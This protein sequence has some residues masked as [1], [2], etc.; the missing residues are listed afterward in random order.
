[1]L[2]KV[3]AIESRSSKSGPALWIAA[4]AV[5]VVAAIALRN[6]TIWYARPIPSL[7]IDPGGSISNLGLPESGKK[8]GLKFPQ[9]VAPVGETK[10]SAGSRQRVAAWDRAVAAAAPVGHLDAW[11]ISE[12]DRRL[13]R[14]PFGPLEPQ[15]W[16]VYAGSCILAGILYAAAGLVALWASPT[17]R[18]SR[19]FA[20]FAISAG[21]LLLT[22][23]DAHTE[24]ALTP[25]FFLAY[26]LV[27][28]TLVLLM[29]NLPI[30]VAA[31]A[32]R[33]RLETVSLGVACAFGVLVVG[34]R[35]TGGDVIPFQVVLTTLFGM[36]F[37]V[38]VAG[39][40]VRYLRSRGEQRQTLRTL[41]V[42]M[43][44]VYAACSAFMVLASLGVLRG[45]PD[46]LFFPALIFAPLASL[47][48]FVRYDLWGSR[49]L[50]SR[51]GTS[52]VVGG[53]A[54]IAAIAAGAAFAAWMGAHFSHALAGAA[55]GGFAAAILV[56]LALRIS[57]FTLFRSRA[58]YKPT[59]E[60][61]G[62]ELTTLTSVEEVGQA[63]ESTVR[64]WLPC[65]SI[66]LALAPTASVSQLAAAGEG[67][68]GADAVPDSAPAPNAD[69]PPRDSSSELRMQVSFAGK[70]LGWLDVGAKRGG[71][72]FTSDDMDLLRAIANHGGLALAH[73]HAYQ[74]LEDRR[75]AQAQAWRGEREALV[76]TVAAEMAHEIRYPINY[77][78]SL[79]ERSA[80]GTKL[81]A[82]DIDVGRE[83]VD[84]LERLVSG[85]KRMA[86]HRIERS[87]TNV[88][89][90]CGRVEALLRDSLGKRPIE[91]SIGK[92]ATLR[93]DPDK[94]TQVLVNL[95][96]N[97]LEA[98]G[99]NGRVG[100]DWIATAQ[101]GE[102]R[103]WD[104]GPGFVG[105]ASRLFA[106]WYT[107]KPRGTGLGL[108][109]THRLVRAHGWNVAGVR[110]D[111][112]TV[113]TVSV[114]SEDI[115]RDSVPPKQQSGPEARV[116]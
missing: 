34:V 81:E 67:A 8:L 49:R 103:V 40:L 58:E 69:E 18:L 78:R 50:L 37:A 105:E 88:G 74:E 13:V 85:L 35:Q 5:A 39:F 70:P 45:F 7:L 15:A 83:E 96:S 110:R 87:P 31:L 25:V 97:G 79:F 94:M 92:D 42:S 113:F 46:F 38:S 51:I 109:I 90:L 68:D 33:P 98:C 73:A 6:A 108:A 112:R 26:S 22:V 99:P 11:V 115:V 64:R 44:P 71:A 82:E 3:R 30:P 62:E 106:P 1:M 104:D 102:L 32:K 66:R 23:F 52:L 57:D 100:V 55:G 61:L 80:T 4:A 72:L 10:G 75:Q 20:R 21:V 41:V 53:L 76:E 114:R 54:C 89:D 95:L 56:V 65:E 86:A 107:T 63:I 101:G 29:L 84:R 2:P 48:A 116:A 111:S 77:F 9:R 12:D 91:L 24:R 59:I 27:P 28:P 16:W 47:Y 60:K 93:C 43:I 19:A 36:S 14:L 17:G